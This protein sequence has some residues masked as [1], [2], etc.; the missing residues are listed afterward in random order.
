[1]KKNKNNSP[2]KDEMTV[3][4]RVQKNIESTLTV[5]EAQK[6]LYNNT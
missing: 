3:E 4:I 6:L 2:G 1:M 5:E